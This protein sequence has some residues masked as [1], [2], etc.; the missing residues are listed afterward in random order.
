[1]MAVIG[2]AL[3]SRTRVIQSPRPTPSQTPE[4]SP[5]AYVE[6]IKIIAQNLKIPWDIRFLPDGSLLVTERAGQLSRITPDGA[7]INIPVSGIKTGGEGGLLGLA[8]HPDYSL[9]NWIYLY[10]GTPTSDG[11]TNK[12]VRYKLENDQLADEKVIISGIPGALYHDGGRLEFGPDRNLYITTGDATKDYLAQDKKSLAGKI[13]RLNDDGTIPWDNPFGT[14]VYSYGHRNPQGLAWDDSGRL[15]E[16]EHGRSG[17]LSGL[18][19][20]NLIVKGDNYGW[21]AIEGDKTK[22]A[23]VTSILNSGPDVTWAP[24]SALYYK[25]SIYYGGLRGEGLYRAILNND[26]VASSTKY[27]NGQFG[28]IRTVRLGP[29]GLFY[30]TTSNTDGRGKPQDGDDKIIRIDPNQLK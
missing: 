29:D 8:L 10:V 6:P 27:F 21:P 14:A 20:L 12:V 3:W 28:R 25:G 1:M 26:K 22:E 13:L 5:S 23:M 15:W 7:K 19:E 30:L 9:N 2:L 24:A 18:D 11:T 16:T 4:A 17:V